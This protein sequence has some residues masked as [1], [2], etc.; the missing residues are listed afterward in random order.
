MQ[1]LFVPFNIAALAKEK[2]FNSHCL[3]YYAHSKLTVKKARY[4]TI[5]VNNTLAPLYQQLIDWFIV[6]HKIEVSVYYENGIGW[7]YSVKSMKNAAPLAPIDY[8]KGYYKSL[9]K[10]FNQAFKLIKS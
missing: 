4:N 3:A 1:H 10:A 8:R 9:N 5:H 7:W 2:G 6:N